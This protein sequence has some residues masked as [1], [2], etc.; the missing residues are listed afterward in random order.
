MLPSVLTDVPYKGITHTFWKLWQVQSMSLS[1]WVTL[2]INS[3]SLQAESSN[4]TYAPKKQ[5]SCQ[6]VSEWLDAEWIQIFEMF[7]H[8]W[9]AWGAWGRCFPQEGKLPQHFEQWP[10]PQNNSQTGAVEAAVSVY[11]VWCKVF[12]ISKIC[13]GAVSRK[14]QSSQTGM[15]L[16][17][18]ILYV[19]SFFISHL[20]CNMLFSPK[21]CLV[22]RVSG[23]RLCP[24]V[25]DQIATSPGPF[26][27]WGTSALGT[28]CTSKPLW[29]Q[30][31]L[32]LFKP[33]L[34]VRT[35]CSKVVINTKLVITHLRRK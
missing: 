10:I 6:L 21:L 16:W 31:K 5:V 27:A 2:L 11:K 7:L 1:W 13:I 22:F 23:P 18:I 30:K 3:G 26:M 8:F 25:P 33:T 12:G 35:D 28:L 4:F 29:L 20:T 9:A 15:A 34:Y 19:E 24:L 17:D 14:I 32:H